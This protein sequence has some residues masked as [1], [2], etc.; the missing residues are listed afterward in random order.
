[1]LEKKPDPVPLDEIKFLPWSQMDALYEATVEAVE[2]AVLNA[3]V[4]NRDAIGREGT[5]RRLCRMLK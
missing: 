3:L 2:E 5:F 4:N 1:M